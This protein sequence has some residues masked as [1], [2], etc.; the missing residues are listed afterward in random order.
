[1][2]LNNKIIHWVA[3]IVCMAIPVVLQVHGSWQ[4]ITIGAVLNAIYLWASQKLNPTAPI[5]S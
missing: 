1:M 5:K 3:F 2:V 4:D